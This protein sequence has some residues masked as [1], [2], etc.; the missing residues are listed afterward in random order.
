VEV[1]DENP[2]ESE[3]DVVREAEA[4]CPSATIHVD[5]DTHMTRG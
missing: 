5:D 2:P 4:L 3:W 1:I